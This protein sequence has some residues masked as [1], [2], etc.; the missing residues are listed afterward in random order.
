MSAEELPLPT[1]AALPASTQNVQ[2][3]HTA[4]PSWA[5]QASSGRG[6][7]RERDNRQLARSADRR[8]RSTFPQQ[9]RPAEPYCDERRRT[10]SVSQTRN[11]FQ[12]AM[13]QLQPLAADAELQVSTNLLGLQESFRAAHRGTPEEHTGM[14]RRVPRTAPLF[15]GPVFSDAHTILGTG[16]AF[17]NHACDISLV[18]SANCLC[19]E[20]GL[21]LQSVLSL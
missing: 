20:T 10:R 5:S 9:N 21:P 14:E 4:G 3:E 17:G 15:S 1:A 12:A 2:E 7:R 6:D 19:T 11:Q 13:A 16:R 18:I 8:A